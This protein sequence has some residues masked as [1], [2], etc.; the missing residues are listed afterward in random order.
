MPDV[1]AAMQV[2]DAAALRARIDLPARPARS[3]THFGQ[4]SIPTTIR[5]G[6]SSTCGAGS[7]S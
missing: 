3:G 7:S 6:R 4:D 5:P 1:I 2:L